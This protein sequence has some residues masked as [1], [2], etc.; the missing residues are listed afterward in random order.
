MHATANSAAFICETWPH[1]AEFAVVDA[2]RSG[3]SMQCGQPLPLAVFTELS[4]FASRSF[5]NDLR[6]FSGELMKKAI[7]ISLIALLLN[8]ASVSVFAQTLRP[9]AEK[10]FTEA[11]DAQI[12]KTITTF[13][14]L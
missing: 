10:D 5:R 13:P 11:Y 4:R 12:R 8:A 7:V 3:V 9:A 2:R 6:N 1:C 14:D